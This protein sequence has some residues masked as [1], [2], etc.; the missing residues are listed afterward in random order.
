MSAEIAAAVVLY[1]PN[2]SVF[3]RI[4]AAR[5]L[6][7]EIIVIDNSPQP[8]LEPQASVL[9]QFGENRGIGA[10]LNRAAEEARNLGFGWLLTL[11]QDTVIPQDQW[12]VFTRSFADLP[13]KDTIAIF[14]PTY[15]E[16]DPRALGRF[17]D[18]DLVMT[19]ANL[20]NLA[21]HERLG[22]FREDLFIDE[23]DHEYCL[24]AKSSGFRIVQTRDVLLRHVP[25]RMV[26]IVRNGEV[27]QYPLYAP[28][29]LYTMVRN[30]LFLARRYYRRYPAAVRG[31]LKG[32]YVAVKRKLK[33]EPHKLQTLGQVF[34]GSWHWLIGRYGPPTAR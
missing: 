1:N 14:A 13:E 17:N 26:E 33:Y 30:T 25:G 4:E 29:R 2:A 28:N 9:V 32:L 5:S 19:S 10:A 27:I 22:G 18:V 24:R 12:K 34:R 31:R 20:L 23:V 11:D 21:I 16:F 3:P 8:T 6:T 7:Q 15:N